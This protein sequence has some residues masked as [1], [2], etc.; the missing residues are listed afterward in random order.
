MG[1]RY[2]G[3]AVNPQG[4]APRNEGL[5]RSRE[6]PQ[7]SSAQRAATSGCGH[8]CRWRPGHL[9]DN[10]DAH[11]RRRGDDDDHPAPGLG[12]RAVGVSRKIA[13]THNVR[14]ALLEFI[15]PRHHAI[16]TTTRR[17]GSRGRQPEAPAH[18]RRGT[19]TRFLA[20]I[21]QDNQRATL[22]GQTTVGTGG[23]ARRV[24]L[25]KNFTI[26][27]TL[28]WTIAQRVNGAYIE[29]YGVR[30]DVQLDVRQ[31]DISDGYH[32]FRERLLEVISRT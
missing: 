7:T 8:G 18:R 3:G 25:G 10:P 24:R 28:T 31:D 29:N 11:R 26:D 1:G 14:S 13:T 32:L 22:V 19:H 21:M 2:R 30:P 9:H 17:D 20:A 5:D 15:R 23:L 12:L 4:L 6:V 16:V 27:A